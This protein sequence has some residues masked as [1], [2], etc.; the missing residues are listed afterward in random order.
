V[1]R[2]DGGGIA[3]DDSHLTLLCDGLPLDEPHSGGAL[4]FCPAFGN[5]QHHARASEPR[6]LVAHGVEPRFWMDVE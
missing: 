1:R 6:Q 4:Q 3:R 2:L 5:I